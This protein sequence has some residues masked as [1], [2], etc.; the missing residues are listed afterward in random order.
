VVG[1]RSATVAMAS[2]CRALLAAVLALA[3]Q[4]AWAEMYCG[5]D[6]C[7][8]LLGLERGADAAAI[9]KAYRKLSLQWHPDKN[10]DNKEAATAKFQQIATAYEVLSDDAV[11]EAYDYFLDHPEEHMYNKMRYY[12]AVYQ[13]QTPLWA[14]L[15]GLVALASCGQ[16]YHWNDRYKA[17]QV[18]PQFAKML[19]EEYVRNCTRGRHG[20]QTGELTKTMKAEIK[21]AFLE[22]LAEDPDVPF[23]VP[24]WSNTLI[25]T[26]VYHAPIMAF[27]WLKWRI[28]NHKVIEEEKARD[29]EELRRQAQEEQ[30][31]QEKEERQAAEKEDKKAKNAALLAERQKKEQEKRERW[32]EEAKK[33]AEEQAARQAGGGDEESLIVQ[34]T[35]SSVE[36]LRK[37]GNFLVEISYGSDG[38]VQLVVDKTIQVGQKAKVAL[39]GAT[40]PN[41][42]VARRS[43]V[44]GEWSEGVLLELGAASTPTASPAQEEVA[45]G[46]G[47]VADEPAAEDISSADAGDS[48]ARQRKKKKG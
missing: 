23:Q 7:Y 21:T 31:A 3:W 12:Q 14:V 40:M 33:E 10:R 44:A 15:L 9:K 43:K 48:K 2:C 38:R 34:G 13:P 4:P 26:M 22:Q 42:N 30:D 27:K 16:Y 29:A 35:V 8:E 24:K 45:A 19:E 5:S 37:K 46:D 18:S 1:Q 39:E 6:N 32:A 17:F 25:P 36:E 20:Y 41:G 28:T 11:R 47:E